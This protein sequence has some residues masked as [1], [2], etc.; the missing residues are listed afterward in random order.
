MLSTTVGGLSLPT[1]VYNASG[2]R[3]GSSE[4]LSR[5]SATRAGAVLSK[6]AT[7]E[8]QKGNPLPRY[9]NG[10]DLG[11]EMCQGSMNSEGLPNKGFAYYNS[12]ETSGE[13]LEAMK[14]EKPFILSLSGLKLEDNLEMIKQ[15]LKNDAASSIE[16]NLA[17][18]NIPGKP[19]IAYDFQQLGDVLAA[20]GKIRS[21]KSKPLGV[22]LAPYFDMPHIAEAARIINEHKSFV[23]YVV[24]CN[25]IGNALIVDSDNEMAAIVPKGGYG[26]LAGGYIKYTALANVKKLREYLD[27]DIDIVGVGGV[28]SGRDAFEL[29]LCGASAVQVGTQHWTEGPRCFDR[30]CGE[31]EELMK[32]KGYSSIDDFRGK[33][34]EFQKG[35][36]RKK[37]NLGGD[38]NSGGKVGG[39]GNESSLL[40]AIIVVLLAIIAF[41]L[42]N[43]I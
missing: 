36:P 15:A 18:P 19:T 4:A 29:I 35:A 7:L 33:L 23:R 17:C 34:R 25:T 24:T 39:S 9:V 26:G 37:I 5:I 32:K 22:K 31:L 40:R 1:C 20:V 11:S 41:L 14:G 2:P 42:Q 3:T 21:I 12:E 16:L 30:I 6:S 28:R 10:I 43:K 8:A 38:K 13:V 27:D